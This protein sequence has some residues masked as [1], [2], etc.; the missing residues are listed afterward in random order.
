MKRAIIKTSKHVVSRAPP[1]S[2]A[3]LRQIISF[4]VNLVPVPYVIIVALILGFLTLMR[5][6][7][8]VASSVLVHG[9]HVLK[10]SDVCVKN[11][12]LH[13]TL[14]SSKTR[15]RIAPPVVFILPAIPNSPCCPVL[16]WRRYAR[17]LVPPPA[18][19]ALLLPSGKPLTAKQLL[20]ALRTVSLAVFGVEKCFTLHSLRR[21]A[22]QACDTAGLPLPGIMEAGT[23]RSNAVIAYLER[24]V[25]ADAPTALTH[26]L[27]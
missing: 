12:V 19:P 15:S 3:E 20:H 22:A 18:S 13:V 11:N 25:V 14:R 26:L 24:T 23:W 27:V 7:N 10:F 9:P 6:S 5:Q 16:A 17:L 2:P 8:L 4:L 21:G 1:M